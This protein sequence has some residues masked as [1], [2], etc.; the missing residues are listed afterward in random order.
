MPVYEYHCNDCN[1]DYSVLH[2]IYPAEKQI[3]S[4]KCGECKGFLERKLSAP[5]INTHS[6]D[7]IDSK[8]KVGECPVVLL[9]PDC[10]GFGILE[11]YEKVRH[12]TKNPN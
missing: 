3:K 10:I 5:N 8:V 4:M 1:K 7:S 11:A 2:K 12:S 6:F 9:G